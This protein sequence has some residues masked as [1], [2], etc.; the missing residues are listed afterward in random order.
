MSDTRLIILGSALAF[1]GFLLGGLSGAQ[2]QQYVVQAG[3]FDVCYD[4]SPDGNAVKVKCDE[5]MQ[6]VYFTLAI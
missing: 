2:Y 3:Q 5:K 4:Y 1:A 6:D